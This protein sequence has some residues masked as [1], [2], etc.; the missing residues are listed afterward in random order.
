[1]QSIAF[2]YILRQSVLSASTAGAASATPMEWIITVTAMT[3]GSV[4]LMWIG[5]LISE[6]GI[7]NGISA[8]NLHRNREPNANNVWH[9]HNFAV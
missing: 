4:L 1:M 2:I 5:E 9:A 6:Q 8:N 7:G 3:A